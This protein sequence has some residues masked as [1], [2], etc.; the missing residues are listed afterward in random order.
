[1]N[2]VEMVDRNARKFG[3][4]DAIRYQGRGVSFRELKDRAERAAGVLQARGIEPG[5][6]VA[7][8]SQNTPD[9]VTTFFGAQ[10]AGAAVVPVNHKLAAPEVRYILEHSGAKIFLFDGSLAQNGERPQ[11]SHPPDRPGQPGSGPAPAGGTAGIRTGV[12]ARGRF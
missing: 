9:F 5:D 2:L 12:P 11:P 3:S 4:K 8:M 6:V 7:V 1:M 10:K